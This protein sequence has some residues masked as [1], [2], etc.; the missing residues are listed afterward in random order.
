MTQAWDKENIWV[1]NMNRT[2]HDELLNT[3]PALYP[4]SY[5]NLWRAKSSEPSKDRASARWAGGHGFDSCWELRF[6][7]FSTI[8]SCWSVQFSHKLD[9]FYFRNTCDTLLG[10][11][12]HRSNSKCSG[13]IRKSLEKLRRSWEVCGKRL[14]ILG[15]LGKIFGLAST[16][17]EKSSSV[18]GLTS[19]IL[20]AICSGSYTFCT[21]VKLFCTALS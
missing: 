14:I 20:I 3:R 7:H 17:F 16:N 15:Y 13:N 6:F 12:Y 18:F 11:G 10:S 8:V 5:E 21:G 2:H 1:P 19:E 4:L 9:I